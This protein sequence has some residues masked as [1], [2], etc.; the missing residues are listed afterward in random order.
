MKMPFNQWVKAIVLAGPIVFFPFSRSYY[1]FYVG[2]LAFALVQIRLPALWKS[3]PDLRSAF[4][5]F[6]L[7]ILLTT[8]Y[9]LVFKGGAH[10]KWMGTFGLL[11]LATVLGLS[12]AGLC[13]DERI[14]KVAQGLIGIAVISWLV[15]GCVQLLVGADINCRFEDSACAQAR[16]VSLYFSGQTKLS[17][18]IGMMALLPAYWLFDQRQKWLA[19]FVLC[20]AAAVVMATGSRFGMLA[21]MLGCCATVITLTLSF[22]RLLRWGIIFATPLL[23]ILFAVVFYYTN[24]A[25]HDRIE[26]TATV[27]KGLDYNALNIALA[28]RL[29]IWFPGVAL[30]LDHWLFGIGPGELSAAIRPYLS[31]ENM[32]V[33]HD[34]K[35]FHAHQVMLEIWITAGLV[36]L[37]AFFA[38]YFRVV[39]VY[40]RAAAAGINM[41]V[42]AL[43]VFLLMWFPLSTPHGFY[44][45]ELILL[46]FY[47]LGL[48]FGWS[49]QPSSRQADLNVSSD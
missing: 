27:F 37:L 42:A 2:I 1:I 26:L 39:V 46:T 31:P 21:F 38:Y 11:G 20:A 47:M 30:A 16:N 15:D 33:V 41:G 6:A 22:P 49:R 25:F 17:Y 43:L 44:S 19:L 8:V 3:W 34:T 40:V 48:G 9:W 45:S 35:I 10:G 5:A 29:D 14:K 32:F 18:Y 13:Q 4:Y 12:T 7:P 28:W 24:Q 36:G 23:I